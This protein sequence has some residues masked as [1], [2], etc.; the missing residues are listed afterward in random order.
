MAPRKS[1]NT[2][3]SGQQIREPLPD[4]TKENDTEA[5][6]YAR[7]KLGSIRD[8][9]DRYRGGKGKGTSNS[10]ESGEDVIPEQITEN[11]DEL[12]DEPH[13][14]LA[15]SS[16]SQP[17]LFGSGPVVMLPLISLEEFKWNMPEKDLATGAKCVTDTNIGFPDDRSLDIKE[18][19]EDTHIDI[20]R[21]S[22][23]ELAQDIIDIKTRP[24]AEI[25]DGGDINT[26]LEYKRT[27]E[28]FRVKG[29]TVAKIKFSDADVYKKESPFYG[30]LQTAKQFEKKIKKELGDQPSL[31]IE[32]YV[33]AQVL[34]CLA[35]EVGNR[36]EPP[37]LFPNFLMAP[38]TVSRFSRNNLHRATADFPVTNR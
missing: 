34:L 20:R 37:F 16:E 10:L 38:K 32:R 27:I 25:A 29:R 19:E 5:L 30:K 13:E 17:A 33:I 26:N 7:S 6:A 9:R 28:T 11:D 35:G 21:P 4:R 1:A 14:G 3:P 24:A 22:V 12:L 36:G 23:A 18:F 8:R 15:D 31:D 2:S